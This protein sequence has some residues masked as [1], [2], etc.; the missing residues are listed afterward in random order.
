MLACLARKV[1]RV[2][3]WLAVLTCLNCTR[4][5]ERSLHIHHQKLLFCHI[6]QGTTEACKAVSSSPAAEP[7]LLLRFAR[8]LTLLLRSC[9]ACSCVECCTL[10]CPSVSPSDCCGVTSVFPAPALALTHCAPRHHRTP[11]DLGAGLRVAPWQIQQHWGSHL[12]QRL[13]Q[14]LRTGS[15][16][17]L[18]QHGK[19][20]RGLPRPSMTT[21]TL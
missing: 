14:W 21:C 4:P 18:Q 1:G 3:G 15:V 2:K 11:A 16:Q 13:R 17:G 9:L 12:G 8:L 5:L 6:L 19:R 7:K 20:R 10:L